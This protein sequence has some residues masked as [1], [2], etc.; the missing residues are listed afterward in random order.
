MIRYVLR[1]ILDA[2]PTMLLVLTLVFVALR[3]LPGHYHRAIRRTV[4]RGSPGRVHRRWQHGVLM[5]DEARHYGSTA[6]AL[7]SI[8]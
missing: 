1:R 7:I 5:H 3:L 2:I 8:R 4:V 6:I